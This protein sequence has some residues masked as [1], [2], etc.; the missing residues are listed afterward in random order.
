[1]TVFISNPYRGAIDPDIVEGKKMISKMTAGLEEK[2]KFDM[3][4]ENIIE[5]RDNLEESVNMY[6][7]ESVVYA[8]P[9]EHNNNGDMVAIANLLTEPNSVPL[10][11]M[12]DF[13]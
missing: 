3:K 4:Q 6:C 1:M 12:M 13:V 9:I 11:Y 7:Y 10:E 8:I 2:D 5:F